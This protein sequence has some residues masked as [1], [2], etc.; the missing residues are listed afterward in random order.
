M[1]TSS[2]PTRSSLRTASVRTTL[3]PSL[4]Y[5]SF[6]DQQNPNS[7]HQLETA[8]SFEDI[9]SWYVPRAAG[10]HELKFGTQ[11]TW[12]SAQ[13]ANQSNMNGTFSFSHDLPFNAADPRTYPDRLHGSRA[14][15]VE[16]RREGA[17]HRLVRTGQVEAARRSSPSASVCATT[18]KSFHSMKSTTR[19]SRIRRSIPST[20]TISPRA[21]ASATRSTTQ[22]V[23]RCAAASASSTNARPSVSSTM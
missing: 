13:L 22:A 9:L 21:S 6:L 16:L 20:P 5:Q 14:G 2:S 17:H 1:R 7:S 23:P 3:L 18:S 15:R 4:S 8:Y 11:Y 10:S 12:M 19:G